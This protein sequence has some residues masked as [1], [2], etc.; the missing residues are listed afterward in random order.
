MRSQLSTLAIFAWG[1]APDDSGKNHPQNPK[2]KNHNARPVHRF[3]VHHGEK[4]ENHDHPAKKLDHAEY[5]LNPDVPVA[6]RK[7]SLVHIRQNAHEAEKQKKYSYDCLKRS[8]R[9]IPSL[10]FFNE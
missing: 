7:N 1:G 4:A 8:Y 5:D 6:Y 9:H 2:Y 10:Y 3:A